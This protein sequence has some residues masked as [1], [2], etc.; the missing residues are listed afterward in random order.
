MNVRARQ[1]DGQGEALTIDEEMQLAA[2]LAPICGV[3]SSVGSAPWCRNTDE[4][5]RRTEPIQ[6]PVLLCMVEQDAPQAH[7]HARTLPLVKATLIG[8][9]TPQSQS[10]RQ[11]TPRQPPPEEIQ[12]ASEGP[13]VDLS[14]VTSVEDNFSFPCPEQPERVWGSPKM[15]RGSLLEV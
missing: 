10:K 15:T 5:Q 4:V 1:A 2:G 7:S 11:L 14:S 8:P 12:D 9:S 13:A 6:T 3:G